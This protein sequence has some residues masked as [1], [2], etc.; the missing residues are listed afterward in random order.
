MGL[1]TGVA[2]NRGIWPGRG[3]LTGGHLTVHRLVYLSS[4]WT[5][6]AVYL[7]SHYRITACERC[8]SH[9]SA[10]WLPSANPRYQTMSVTITTVK[11]RQYSRSHFPA[12]TKMF[13]GL[14]QLATLCSL[15]KLLHLTDTVQNRSCSPHCTQMLLVY[16]KKRRVRN[17]SDVNTQNRIAAAR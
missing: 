9:Q 17:Y 10:V 11:I 13:N 4:I 8:S 3:Q 5:I 1:L 6:M 16:E 2:K 14:Q 12:E 7:T 15:T